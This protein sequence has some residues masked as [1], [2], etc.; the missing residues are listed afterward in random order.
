MKKTLATAL[1][2]ALKN[3]CAAGELPQVE[4]PEF[5]VNNTKQ[6]DHGDLASNLAMQLARP[7]KANPR[8]IAEALVNGLGDAGGLIE[9]TEIAGPGF[10]NFFL[11]PAAWLASLPEVVER[12]AD[13]GR[14]DMGQG[15]KVLVEFVSANPTGPLHVG[16]GRGAALGDAL[17]R[18]LAFSGYEAASEYYVNDAGNQMA[19]LGRSIMHRAREL[20]GSGDPFPDNH[21]K[22][23]YI[24]DLA[25]ELLAAPEGKELLS[26]PDD[27]AVTLASAWA[28]DKILKGIEDD[29]A[30]FKVK[31][32]RWFSE[33]SLV[34]DGAVDRAFAEMDKRGLLYESEGAL[35]FKACDFGDE[36]DRVVKRSNGEITYF[37]SDI[38]YHLD[39]LRRGYGRLIDVWGADHH[40][41]IPRVKAALAG[42][43]NRAD[44]LTVV[45][46][47]MVNLLRGGEPV[48]MSTRGGE[49]VTLKEVIDEVGADSA[50]FIFLT[51]RSDTQLDFDL[52]VAKAHSMDNPVFYVQ[53]AHT[54]VCAL[55]RKAAE[56]GVAEPIP[57]N[58]DLSRLERD[59]EVALAR[60]LAEFPEMVR[61]AAESLEPHRITYYLHDLAGAFHSYYNASKVLVGD[62]A[63]S[64]A[65]LLLVRAVGQ[66]LAN[67]LELLGV[68]APEKM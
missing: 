13:Y 16:H 34:A 52:E 48:A 41:Y 64:A 47:Q 10:I 3:L 38:A 14:G 45:L 60:R 23:G 40:G 50:R 20:N 35:W 66:V 15:Q 12:G 8:A 28:G 17:A 59:D 61:G 19:T 56:A 42:L 2:N 68:N 57:G 65:R 44:D 39:K 9:R 31:I 6:A 46:V 54:R 25:T 63:L 21:Y 24:K 58:V 55:F 1:E 18:L 53:Y 5:A 26:L 27:E 36:K 51:R 32:G 11:K 33:N 4:T 37:A 43:E 49:F 29:L 62:P 30:T 67:G 7:M 22:G